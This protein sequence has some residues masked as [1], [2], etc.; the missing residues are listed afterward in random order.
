[1]MMGR[2][3]AAILFGCVLSASPAFAQDHVRYGSAIKLSPVF[4]LPILAAQEKG[5]FKKNNVDVEWIPS[6]SG[7]D[8]MRNFASSTIDMASSTGGTDIPAI[9][10]GVPA[11]ITANLQSTDGFAFWVLANS[12]FKSPKDLK[13]AKLG[14]SRLGG[15]EH[16]Y[17]LL[18]AK[19]LGLSS[20]IQFIG[21][22]GVRE[23]LALLISG[24]VD[25][26][27]LNLQNLV[28]LKLQGKVRELLSLA[29]FVPKPWFSYSITASK[30][31]IE[32]RP[33]VVART[34]SSLFEANRFIESAEGK[35]WTIAKMR[36]M[37]G[38]SEKGAQEV[39]QALNLSP[40]GKIDRAAIQNAITFMTEYGILKA[41]EGASIDT[42]FTD[43]FVR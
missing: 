27:V 7:P 26:V 22:G 38:Y 9:S 5:I 4:Y 19:Q 24:N 3:I 42:V 15:V 10:R 20:S 29:S 18:A 1:M 12:R 37:N 16:A 32:R 43:R 13:G 40:D 34:L 6:E 21:S 14:V 41:G 8:M 11:I 33:D 25:G 28:D 36:E 23:S 39:Y 17:G 30:A 35:P 31:M 2:S